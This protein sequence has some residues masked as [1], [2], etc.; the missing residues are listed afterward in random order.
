MQRKNVILYSI[1][2]GILAVY[3]LTICLVPL[4]NLLACDPEQVVVANGAYSLFEFIKANVFFETDAYFVYFNGGPTWIAVMMIFLQLLLMIG[5]FVVIVLSIFELVT[6]KRENLIL[7]QNNITKKLTILFAYFAF[8]VCALGIASFII[9]TAL[10]NG[11]IVMSANVQYY[12]ALVLFLA[13]IVV[14]HLLDKNTQEQNDCKML[15]CIGYALNALFALVGA[16]LVF[17]PQYSVALLGEDYT[18][19]WSVAMQ[20]NFLPQDAYAAGGDFVLGLSQYVMFSLFLTAAFLFI[21]SCIGFILTLANKKTVWLSS[22]IK[23]WSI[24]YLVIYTLL[25]IFAIATVCVFVSTLY[26]IDMPMFTLIAYF[27]VFVPIVVC[28]SSNMV[29]LNKNK[30]LPLDA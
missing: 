24:T 16:V 1:L 12:V 5:A 17:V 15:N 9:T 14:A 19:L 20:A 28:L 4:V 23:R 8:M 21:Y 22:R 30:K 13:C 6:I 27:A 7:K 26:L 18:S 25:Y 10:A 2:I 29:S 3:L 11:F